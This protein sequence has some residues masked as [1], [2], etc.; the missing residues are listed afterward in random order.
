MGA[1]FGER[2]TET[3]SLWSVDLMPVRVRQIRVVCA[4]AIDREARIER[5]HCE[6]GRWC[7]AWFWLSVSTHA[8]PFTQIKD[9]DTCERGKIFFPEFFLFVNHHL[10]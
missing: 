6:L 4:P 5:R 8:V 2:E 1:L 10:N 7:F 3:G 9:T